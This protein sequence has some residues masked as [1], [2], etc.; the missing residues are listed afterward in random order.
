MATR[1]LATRTP[2]VGGN[3]KCNPESPDKIPELIANIN[4]CDTSKCDVYVC[5]VAMH[6]PLVQGKFTNDAKVCPQNCNFTG[7][8]A[9]TGELAVDQV[10]SGQL[11]RRCGVQQRMW[12]L[13]R[14]GSDT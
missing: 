9:F 3:W 13:A 8:G 11:R 4:A 1:A 6:I 5:P 10:R 7:I 14:R 12:Q 2:I